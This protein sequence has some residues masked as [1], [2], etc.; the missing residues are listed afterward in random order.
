MGLGKTLTVLSLIIATRDQKP[1]EGYSN[2][3]L[4]GE[5]LRSG[6]LATS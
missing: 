3:T 5:P 2:A 1:A 6:P 4:V